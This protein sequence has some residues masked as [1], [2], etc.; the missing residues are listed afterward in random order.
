MRAYQTQTVISKGQLFESPFKFIISMSVR[1]KT[2][3]HTPSAV[4][5]PERCSWS[6]R[7]GMLHRRN[8]WQERLHRSSLQ[9]RMKSSHVF[10]PPSP[11]CRYRPPPPPPW[12]WWCPPLWCPPPPPLCPPP[13]PPP[14]LCAPFPMAITREPGFHSWLHSLR[15]KV[16]PESSRLAG[17]LT[18]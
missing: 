14:P 17:D 5:V 9:S 6:S 8:I 3:K 1:K 12:W 10:S 7:I 4:F 13:P 18:V 11:P 2:R 15:G 16:A